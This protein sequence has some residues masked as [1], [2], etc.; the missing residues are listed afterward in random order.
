M[1]M[2]QDVEVTSERGWLRLRVDNGDYWSSVWLTPDEADAL[3]EMLRETAK[4][5]REEQ[6]P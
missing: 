2:N 3:A 4:R 5:I 1:S 6:K